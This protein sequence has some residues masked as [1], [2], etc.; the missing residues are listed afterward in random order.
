MAEPC[1]LCRLDLW[2]WRRE[3]VTSAGLG[4]RVV[5]EMD[6]GGLF[7]T[8]VVYSETPVEGFDAT[9]VETL[10]WRYLLHGAEK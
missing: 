3:H 8:G 2:N 7:Q 1:K 9:E 10:N 5:G 4:Y 6:D